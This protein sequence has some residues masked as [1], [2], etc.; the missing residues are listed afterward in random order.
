MKSSTR[1]W[2]GNVVAIALFALPGLSLIGSAHAACYST[3]RSAVDALAS[4]SSVSRDSAN[5]GYRVSGI[6]SDPVLGLRWAMIARCDHPEWPAVALSTNTTRSMPAHQSEQSSTSNIGAGP[7]VR[8]GEIV[9]LWTQ[10]SLM[11][12]EVVGVSEENGGLGKTIRVRLLRRSTDGQSIPE[13][14]SGIV[15]GPSDVE[16]QPQESN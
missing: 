7:L 2:V 8:A 10:E 13:Q 16:I 1:L 15:R 14:F 5:A 3:P 6:K 9:R 11:R 4:N 12:I